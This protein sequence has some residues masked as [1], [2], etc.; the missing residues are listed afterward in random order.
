MIS[1]HI[2]YEVP[3]QDILQFAQNPKGNELRKVSA[4]WFQ[5]KILRDELSIVR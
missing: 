1:N 3:D 5:I 2:W 4:A